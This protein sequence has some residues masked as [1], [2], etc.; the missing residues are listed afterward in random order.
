MQIPYLP[1]LSGHKSEEA[2]LLLLFWYHKAKITVLASLDSHLEA[3]GEHLFLS[4]G[5]GPNSGPCSCKG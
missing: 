3:L 2:Q 5:L 1:I 4:S